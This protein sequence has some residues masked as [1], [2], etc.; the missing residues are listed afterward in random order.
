MTLEHTI[1]VSA[2]A[3]G[4]AWI[5]RRSPAEKPLCTSAPKPPMKLTPTALAA[6]SRALAYM[7]GSASGAAP[8][9]MAMGVTLMRLFTMGIPYSLLMLSTVETRLPARRVILL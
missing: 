1:S 4:M 7:T 5:R 9:S 8:S 2:K 6:R 3:R